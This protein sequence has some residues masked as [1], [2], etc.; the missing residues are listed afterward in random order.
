MYYA[1]S[2]LG[3]RDSFIGVASSPNLTPG[4]WKDHGPLFRSRP[5]GPYNA[6]DANWISIAGSPFI[7]FGSYWNGIHQVPL[8]GPLALADGAQARNIAYNATGNHAIEAG[9]VIYRRGWYYLTFSAGRAGDYVADP[10][11]PGDEYRIVVCRSPS[12]RGDFVDRDGRSCLTEDGGTTILASHDNV[13]G[14]GGQ[15]LFEDRERG[16]VL[17][18]HYADPRIGL[19]TGEYQFGW[20]VVRWED[21]WPTV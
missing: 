15:G 8:A 14:P 18:Y 7:T 16:W 10:P 2:T 21:G 3:S 4:S 1:V 13:Y 20:N 5:D 6:I 17:Y 9:F 12:G 19:T 11:A